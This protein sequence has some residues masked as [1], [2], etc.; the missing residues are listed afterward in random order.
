MSADGLD[1]KKICDRLVRVVSVGVDFTPWGADKFRVFVLSS[2]LEGPIGS[3]GAG[4]TNPS[5]AFAISTHLPLAPGRKK[6]STIT[7]FHLWAVFCQ[8]FCLVDTAFAN[9]RHLRK[10]TD[11]EELQVVGQNGIKSTTERIDVKLGRKRS[12]SGQLYTKSANL[13]QVMSRFLT[14]KCGSRIRYQISGHDDRS[15]FFG[16]KEVVKSLLWNFGATSPSR[17][18]VG[19]VGGV[20]RASRRTSSPTGSRPAWGHFNTHAVA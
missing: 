3:D 5:H 4:P 9:L 19:C 20:D 17:A 10:L 8:K 14:S 15:V 1:F 11:V 7:F 12:E 13:Y 6:S 16:V 18:G 2:A